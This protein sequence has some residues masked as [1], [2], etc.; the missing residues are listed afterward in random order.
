[1][2]IPGSLQGTPSH[3]FT[4]SSLDSQQQ[5]HHFQQ[6]QQ[7]LRQQQMQHQHQYQIQYQLGNG[8]LGSALP[9]AIPISQA[10][11]TQQQNPYQSHPSAQTLH[12]NQ[13][14]HAQ[15]FDFSPNSITSTSFS[16][17]DR[18]PPSNPNSG[19][20]HPHGSR[21]DPTPSPVSLDITG[22][23]DDFSMWQ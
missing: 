7:Q 6:R 11:Q 13:P 9:P 18:T 19:P 5:F 8:Q 14:S 23:Y 22:I 1:M 4:G 10:S 21:I 17:V 2:Q 20:I 3:S 16:G 12:L 15:P